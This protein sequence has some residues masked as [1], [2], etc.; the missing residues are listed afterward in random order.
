MRYLILFLGVF[1][2]GFE[3]IKSDMVDIKINTNKIEANLN[4]FIINKNLSLVIKNISKLKSDFCKIENYTIFPLYSYKK[5]EK[6]FIGYKSDVFL[7]CVFDKKRGNEFERYLHTISGFAQISINKIG[8]FEDKELIKKEFKI[9]AYSKA[10]KFA[11]ELSNK[12]NKKCF[13]KSVE[14]YSP[15]NE[16]YGKGIRAF[17]MPLPSSNKKKF[18]FYYDVE[19]L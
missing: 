11:K 12:L 14:F 7:K 17:N 19:C 2:F 16:D 9:K 15:N 13:V 4:A 8:Y 1:L 5:K 6:K 3:V 10:E 18:S